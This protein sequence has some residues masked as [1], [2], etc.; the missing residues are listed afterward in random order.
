[1]IRPRQIAL[2]FLTIGIALIVIGISGDR[3]FLYAGIPFLVIALVT[4]LR[5]RR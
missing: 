1:M 5:T 4:L 3:T 2:P